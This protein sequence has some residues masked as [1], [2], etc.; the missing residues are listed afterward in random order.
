M[1]VIYE[2]NEIYLEERTG[3]LLIWATSYFRHFSSE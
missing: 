1:N 3:D 2:A